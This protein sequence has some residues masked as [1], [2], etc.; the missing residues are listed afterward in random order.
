[1]A[2]KNK[3][4]IDVTAPGKRMERG[5]LHPLTQAMDKAGDI[6]QSMGF[7]I[8]DGPEL[9]TEYYNFDALEHSQRPSGAGD[10]RHFW[11]KTKKEDKEKNC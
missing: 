10:A 1:M 2:D 8:A 7:E 4:F 6:F 5:H 11:L 3:K 9:E